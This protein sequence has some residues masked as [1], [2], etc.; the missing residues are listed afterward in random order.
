MNQ[1]SSRP[2]NDVDPWFVARPA[3][4]AVHDEHILAC[5]Q[6]GI[7]VLDADLKCL[8]W[9]P[10]MED[11]TGIGRSSVLGCIPLEWFSAWR[12]AQI[13]SGLSRALAGES[14]TLP[15]VALAGK[16]LPGW[17]APRIGPWKD[18][19][20][21]IRG[22]VVSVRD[23]TARR[24]AEAQLRVQAAALQAAANAIVITDRSGRITWVNPAFTRL[25]GYA[26]DEAVGQNPRLLKSGKQPS[27]AYEAMWRT[28]AA[29]DVWHGEMI[30]RRKN[31]VLYIEEMTITPVHNPAG[32][33]THFIAVK[34]DV[35]ARRDMETE[36]AQS[37]ERFERI[38][39]SNPAAIGICTL[40]EERF[41]DVN[42]SFLRLVGYDREEVIGLSADTLGLWNDHAE[43]ARL[44]QQLQQQ[45]AVANHEI[46]LRTK[47]DQVRDTLVSVER[48]QLGA[49]RC[50]VFLLLDITVRKRLEEQFLQVQKMESLGTLA[51]GVAHDFNNLLTILHGH[52][53]LALAAE[54]LPAR[55]VDSLH[56][57]M[58]ATGRA[59]NLTRQLLTFSRKQPIQP[60]LL[61]LNEVVNN[62][63]K[64]LR[65]IIGEDVLLEVP[66]C[67]PVP[68]IVGDVGMIEQIIVNLAANARDAMPQGGSLR[69]RTKTVRLDPAQA[70][71][72]P[73]ARP[74]L[75]VRLSVRDSG[76]GIPPAVLPRIFEPFFTTKEIG[77]GT[78]LG[79]AIV[80]GIVQQHQGWIEIESRPDHGTTFRLYFPASNLKKSADLDTNLLPK[81]CGGTET[82]LL[83][84]DDPAVRNLVQQILTRYGYT[85]L[86]AASG[87]E[88]LELWNAQ[89]PRLDLLLTDVVMPGGLSGRQLAA[90]L[91]DLKPGLKVI[92]TSGYSPEVAGAT[93]PKDASVQ[94]IP[95]PYL[96]HNLARVVRDCL[97][98]KPP[99]TLNPDLQPA[100]PA[101]EAP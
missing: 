5:L 73:G 99:Q 62:L 44:I 98:G 61:N 36:L 54:P 29:G 69:I 21:R 6:D 40:A 92:F 75:F 42:E 79:L 26:F 34:S 16:T 57:I 37:R 15:D 18:E 17:G 60:R 39:Q 3:S 70:Q 65:R 81:V 24:N 95:K 8:V 55:T 48:I 11:L 2:I 72:R 19:R 13:E 58:E 52:A 78:G 20:G 14:V 71:Q 64:M 53:N 1:P 94:F 90:R 67:P 100:A 97:D 80:H 23:V 7:A 35:T 33:I 74:G 101:T 28:I 68:Y 31:G 30:N 59:A 41:L 51:G 32:E 96:P 46:R 45:G 86:L 49:D 50:L 43:H 83:V 66:N 91:R 82:I 63:T 84:E 47:Q 25:T 76:V 22:V 27:P 9:N 10:A 56:Q 88:A 77:K 85:V 12:Q 38:F 4:P 89:H 87:A 93:D